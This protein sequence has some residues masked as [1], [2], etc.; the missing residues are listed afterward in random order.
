MFTHHS[1]HAKYISMGQKIKKCECGISTP[2]IP[3]ERKMGSE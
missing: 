2:V 1:A 3:R